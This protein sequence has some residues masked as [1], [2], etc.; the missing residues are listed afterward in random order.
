MVSFRFSGLAVLST[1]ALLASAAPA[2]VKPRS[3]VD[4]FPPG[5][6][7]SIQEVGGDG[8]SAWQESKWD[9]GLVVMA[10]QVWDD[11]SRLRGI[12]LTYTDGSTS[13]VYGEPSGGND[14][15]LT[16]DVGGGELVTSLTLWGDGVGSRAGRVLIQTNKQQFN[17]GKDTSSQTGY[18]ADVGGGIITGAFGRAGQDLDALGFLFLRAKITKISITDVVLSQALT[19]ANF[20]PQVETLSQTPFFNSQ[21]TNVS[22][23]FTNSITKSVTKTV[24]TSTAKTL[25]GSTEVDIQFGIDFIGTEENTLKQTFT[26]E[27][28]TTDTS[29]TATQ[30]TVTFSWNIGGTLAP[31]TGVNACARAASGSANNVGYNAQA[32]VYLSDGSQ[33][34]LPETGQY[35]FLVWSQ[36]YAEALPYGQDC[37]TLVPQG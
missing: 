31:G 7:A 8:G 5:P 20:P 10:I 2:V 3:D 17:A 37:T 32:I 30:D 11:G 6:W 26:Y 25:G 28:T 33:F 13:V 19:T 29:A 27:T 14:R 9:S 4:P 15:T 22:W 16:L 34:T 18:P 35:T 24:T 12:Q 21:T 36:S 1:I 23:Q